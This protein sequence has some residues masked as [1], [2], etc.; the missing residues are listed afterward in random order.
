MLASSWFRRDAGRP[1][2][3]RLIRSTGR[4]THAIAVPADVE[5]AVGRRE[6][7]RRDY[8]RSPL[9][10]TPAP[11]AMPSDSPRTLRCRLRLLAIFNDPRSLVC[12]EAGDT[13]RGPNR[14]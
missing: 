1:A 7:W 11:A 4:E 10:A 5:P 3:R 9:R 12:V 8:I 2:A 6:A 14:A 13:H